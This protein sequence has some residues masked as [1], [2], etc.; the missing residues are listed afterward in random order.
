MENGKPKLLNDWQVFLRFQAVAK[1]LLTCLALEKLLTE[2]YH[3]SN[4]SE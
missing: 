3:L 2:D 1:L 4:S